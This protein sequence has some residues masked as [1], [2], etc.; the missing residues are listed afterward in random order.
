MTA[1]PPSHDTRLHLARQFMTGARSVVTFSGA[2][3]SAESGL[4]T[5]RDR[6]T[7]LW[8]KYD[9]MKLASVDG[10]ASDPELV[11]N[12]YNMRRKV[13]AE[14][15]PNAAHRVLASRADLVHITQNVDNL[16]E[17]AGAENVFHLHGTI[18][19][20]RCH[21][22]CGHAEDID[23]TNPPARRECLKCGAPMRPAVVWFGEPLPQDVWARAEQAIRTC[24]LLLVIG[25][26]AVVYPAAGLIPLA[27]SHGATVIIINTEASQTASADVELLGKVGVILPALF[28][29]AAS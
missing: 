12:W 22:G 6:A 26:S 20:D 13:L 24:D 27:K 23:L 15:Q 8:A 25:T 1:H 5:F 14:A 18:W 16:L 7:G 29:D 11:V 28:A 9:P 17:R 21:G 3:L 2:G 10:F 19:R 4:S